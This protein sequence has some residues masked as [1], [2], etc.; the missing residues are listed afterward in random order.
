MRY[1][2][3]TLMCTCNLFAAEYIIQFKRPTLTKTEIA[4][5]PL[6]SQLFKAAGNLYAK[7]NISNTKE[8]QANDNIKYIEPNYHFAALDLNNFTA[9]DP[10][11]NKQWYLENQGHNEPVSVDRMSPL[12]GKIGCDISAAKA[13]QISTGSKAIHIAIVDSGID[14]NHPELRDNIWINTIEQNGQPGIDDDNNGYIDDIYGYDFANQDNDP[15]DDNGHGTHCAGIIGAAHNNKKIMGVLKEVSLIPIKILDKKGHADT[16]T[17]IQGIEYALHTPAT[18]INCSWGGSDNSQIL[19]ELIAKA[20][21][22][23]VIIVAAAG[24]SRGRN[25][26]VDPIFP[27]SYKLENVISVAAHNAQGY[28]SN[29]STRGPHSVHIAAPGTNIIS[30]WPGNQY[31]VA[32]GTSMAAP[33]V[34]AAIGLTQ[35]LYPTW[36]PLEIRNKMMNSGIQ[37]SGLRNRIISE[38]RLDLFQLIKEN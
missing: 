24:N 5:L 10:D 22:R 4:Q 3:F 23:G 20:A 14:Y 34:A 33:I 36:S 12:N 6:N 16:A 2:L 11:F 25:N 8:L 1:L 29:F 38:R 37:E 21:Q 18:V 9:V 7:V 17:S 31:K 28:F 13:W 35:Y 32:S 15:M 30:T 19:K 26:D 27:A